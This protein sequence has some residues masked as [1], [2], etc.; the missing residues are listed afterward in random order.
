MERLPGERKYVGTRGEPERVQEHSL[1]YLARSRMYKTDCA[2]RDS[3]TLMEAYFASIGGRPDIE[4]KTAPKKRKSTTTLPDQPISAKK[5]KRNGASEDL[6]TWTPIF[7][8]WE[9][10]IERVDTVDRDPDTK[11]LNAYIIFKN[12][13]RIK[14]G[15]EMVYKHCPTAMLKFY[16]EHLS[17]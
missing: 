1:S 14:V 2:S 11:K 9:P 10:E 5:S 17:V 3:I 7:K 6:S 4:A 13:K 8:N 15:M 16:E 12:G